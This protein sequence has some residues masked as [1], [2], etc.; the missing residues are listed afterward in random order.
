LLFIKA[1]NIF[2]HLFSLSLTTNKL[3]FISNF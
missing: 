3:T 2:I 1:N